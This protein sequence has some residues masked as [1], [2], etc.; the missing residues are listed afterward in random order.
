MLQLCFLRMITFG[1][2]ADTLGSLAGRYL[3]F[4]GPLVLWRSSFLA[5]L[6]AQTLQFTS[7]AQRFL[8]GLWPDAAVHINQ[9][10]VRA[11]GS[12]RIS[13]TPSISVRTVCSACHLFDD[14]FDF[15]ADCLFSTI[16]QRP[17]RQQLNWFTTTTTTTV[18]T[19]LTTTTTVTT[20]GILSLV[21]PSQDIRFPDTPFP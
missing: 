9:R 11:H 7:L 5:G 21:L 19:S 3:W 8:A 18:T 6:L 17:Q 1:S 20:T 4:F 14:F 2:L 16:S 12:A 13:S 10:A 15:C